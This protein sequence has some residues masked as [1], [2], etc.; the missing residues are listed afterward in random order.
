VAGLWLLVA[1]PAAVRGTAETPAAMAMGGAYSAAA[2]DYEAAHLNP[3]NLSLA[4]NAGL[5]L[6]ILSLAGQAGNSTL[7][8]DDYRR[9]NGSTLDE[10]DK[11][12]ILSR[13]DG[14][15]FEFDVS[16]DAAGLSVTY[17]GLALTLTSTA[18]ATGGLPRDLVELL[19]EGNELDRR[20]DL[21][22]TRG[23]ATALSTVGVSA[24]HGIHQ[25]LPSLAGVVDE[26][27]V[28]GTVRYV[29]GWYYGRIEEASGSLVTTYEGVQGDGLIRRRSSESGSGAALD[30]GVAARRGALRLGLSLG[31]LV[32]RVTWTDGEEVITTFRADSLTVVNAGTGD[33]L[34]TGDEETRAIGDFEVRV[35][36]RLRLG[37]AYALGRWLVTGE[38][39][40]GW[41]GEGLT[42][43][44]AA[45]AAGVEHRTLAWLRLRG[46]L[47]LGPGRAPAISVG[48]GLHAGAARI[49]L[50]VASHGGLLPSQD[51]GVGLALGV[52]LAFR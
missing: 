13:L 4:G 9:L 34:V 45:W 8:V 10:D 23:E 16:G 14:D 20:Y 1:A 39:A 51:E 11:D 19:L 15:L 2:C 48:S 12:S 36:A 25:Y 17:R 46:G 47:S 49:D 7:S 50:A 29:R 5:S 26:L 38:Y 6:H 24:S 43:A 30:L 28:G 32:S 42:P 44:R 3:A 37:A 40:Q 41:G 35:P 18:V 52:G 21:G 31:D 27:T 22:A 33:G